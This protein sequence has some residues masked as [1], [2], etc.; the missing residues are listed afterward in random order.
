MRKIGSYEQFLNRVYSD[1]GLTASLSVN[2]EGPYR[3]ALLLHAVC[4]RQ[5]VKL[6]PRGNTENPITLPMVV[7]MVR[8][9]APTTY[10]EQSGYC[11]TICE[12]LL[13]LFRNRGVA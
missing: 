6:D 3:M 13:L 5:G 10:V 12:A 11:Q 1:E 8:A 7:D 9:V 4:L 2:G